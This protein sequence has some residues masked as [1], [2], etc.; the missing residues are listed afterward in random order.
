MIHRFVLR[1]KAKVGKKRRL[2]M[3]PVITE[4]SSILQSQ[5]C[6]VFRVNQ[7]ANKFDVAYAIK[8]DLG[9]VPLSVNSLVRKGKI[10]RFKGVI[11]RRSDTKLV[12]VRLPADF[13]M[14]EAIV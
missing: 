9:V 3:I 14:P 11:G 5:K 1:D 8:Q 2:L 7:D 12:F 4:K 6:L 10:K 13:E